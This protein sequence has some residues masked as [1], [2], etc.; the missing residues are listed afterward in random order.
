MRRLLIMVRKDLLRQIRSPLSVLIMLSFPLLFALLLALSFGGGPEMPRVRLLVE[1]REK[2]LLSKFLVGAFQSEQFARYFDVSE[3]GPE[4]LQRI[5]NGEASALLRIPEGFS[6]DLL[7][8]RPLALE[9]V[10]NPAEGILPEI[11]E[12]SI[13]VLA[14]GLS[15]GSRILRAPVS[16][17]QPYIEDEREVTQADVQAI[18]AGFYQAIEGAEDLLFPPAILVESVQLKKAEEPG[19]A[20]GEFSIFLFILPGISV[21]A[22]FVLG[23][24]AMRDIL[25]ETRTRTLR[26]QMASPITSAEMVLGKALFT[27]TLAALSLIIIA[28][29]AWISTGRG[30]DAAGFV[31]LSAALIVAVTGLAS[32]IYSLVRTERQGSTL[33]TILLLV[34]AFTGGSFVTLDALPGAV[35]QFAPLSLFY[36][37]TT[38]YQELIQDNGTLADVWPQIG[39]LAGAGAALL[40]VGSF[41]MN[42]KVLA[43]ASE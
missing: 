21:W 36:W 33:S 15:A 17:L 19:E 37:G 29:I 42:R 16:R 34:F 30:A 4:G 23:D 35:R 26:R 22:V 9:L 3:A 13:H 10:R 24:S 8:G 5:E 7:N 2:S 32:V 31:V 38:G 40:V 39:V 28:S 12:Q 25:T 18:A 27:A 20:S 1:D 11:A 14:D 43:G 6:E 41:L